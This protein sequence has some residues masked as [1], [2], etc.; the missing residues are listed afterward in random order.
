MTPVASNAER[1]NR[2]RLLRPLGQGAQG[3]VY[4]AHDPE[5]DRQV[6]IKTLLLN[7][8]GD[9]NQAEQFV[10]AA[11]TASSDATAPNMLAAE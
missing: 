4:A 6:A 9:A 1:I 5:L 8:A 3:I 2:F 11:K 10:A 7:G